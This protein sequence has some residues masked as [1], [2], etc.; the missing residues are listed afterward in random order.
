MKSLWTHPLLLRGLYALAMGRAF[1]RYRNPRRRASGGHQTEFYE[2]TWRQAAEE[3]GGTWT[4]LSSDMSQITVNGSRTRVVH[5]VS[6]IDNPVTLAILH[7]KPLTHRLLSAENLPVPRH[8]VFT[9]KDLQPAA[10]FLQSA[11]R[12]CVVKPAGGTGGG[13]GV[14][15]GIQTLS[16]L[17]R[18]SAAAAVYADE[19]LIEEQIAGDNYRLLYLDGKLIDAFIRR[20]PRVIADGKS[21]VAALVQQ[22]NDERLRNKAGVSQV[23]LSVD[24]DMRRTLAGQGLSLRSVPEKGRMV[25]LKT[26]VNENSGAD[27]TTATEMLCPSIIEDGQRAVRALGV[28]FAGIDIVTTDP[29]VPLAQSGGVILEVNGTPNLYYHYKKADGCF[30][31]AVHLLRRL[32][33]ES[34]ETAPEN[35][36]PRPAA[37]LEPAH[38]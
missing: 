8:A 2:N 32:L 38:A 23:L 31:V 9:L 13:R 22:V 30:P 1:L 25:T 26:V 7:D 36:S 33:S 21:S 18:A 4:R 24:L 3:L 37:E 14:T 34:V 16:H 12:N 5:N 29:S 15:T 28:R 20:L 6:E 35:R 27:N 17:A 11:G 10:T 19:L